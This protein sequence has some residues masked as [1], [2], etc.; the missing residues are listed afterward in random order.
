MFQTIINKD[1]SVTVRN[2]NTNAEVIIS[3]KNDGQTLIETFPK[4]DYSRDPYQSI[5]C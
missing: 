1:G 3:E 2:T 4:G 5:T